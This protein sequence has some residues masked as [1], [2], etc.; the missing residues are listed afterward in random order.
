VHASSTTAAP[1]PPS[2]DRWPAP[3][4]HSFWHIACCGPQELAKFFWGYAV[5]VAALILVWLLKEA[6]DFVRVKADNKRVDRSGFDLG[7]RA[8]GTRCRLLLRS[9]RMVDPSWWPRSSRPAAQSVCQQCG[10][11]H[12]A[13]VTSHSGSARR[14]AMLGHSAS[15]ANW[16]SSPPA[17]QGAS[18]PSL[19]WLQASKLPGG[20]PMNGNFAPV[21]LQRR[22]KES[23][24]PIAGHGIPGHGVRSK[25]ADEQVT[26]ISMRS[27]LC[28]H[29]PAWRPACL[30]A[31]CPAWTTMS[32]C[33][34]QSHSRPAGVLDGVDEHV[35]QTSTLPAALQA[36]MEAANAAK[37][38]PPVGD[39][40]NGGGATTGLLH[41]G[42][43]AAG[44]GPTNGYGGT[45]GHLHQGGAAPGGVEMARY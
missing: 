39:S 35:H 10:G 19:L 4:P 2:A 13:Q 28:I 7:G 40:Y 15:A 41:P 14:H 6:I 11:S 27:A 22:P 42:A 8:A 9:R 43:A 38:P 1:L 16:A 12:V 32:W 23:G 33:V 29:S 34:L 45:T 20:I 24:L 36:A 3:L 31:S 18:L 30:L 5:I 37:G 21:L 17:L 25:V 26:A 44:V